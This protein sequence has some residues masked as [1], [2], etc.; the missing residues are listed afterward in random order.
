MSVQVSVITPTKNRLSLLCE[1]IDSVQAQT[2]G[3]WEHLIVD[4]GSDDGTSEEVARHAAADPRIRYIPRVSDHAGANV[5]R[6]IGIRESRGDLIV[7]L[8]SDDLLAPGCLRQRVEVLDR[9]RDLD[10]AVFPSWVFTAAADEKGQWFIP[11]MLGS[12][13]DLFLYLEH[14][15]PITGPIWRRAALE[16]IGSLSEDLLSWQD[17]DLN[18]RALTGRLKYLRFDTPDHH[19]RWTSDP[20]KT[21]V[22]QFVSP[23]HL[24]GATVIVQNFQARLLQRGLMTWVRRR[25]L[26]GLLFLL[27][28]RW[29]RIGQLSQGLHVWRDAYRKGLV[30]LFVYGAGF[31]V[32]M[33]FKLKILGPTYSERLLERF[34]F[35]VRFRSEP[36]L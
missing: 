9:N 13:L 19:I 27:A 30:P 17:V 25:A 10:F 23:S 6:N 31:L 11:P 2:F 28:E 12:D 20:T 4:D 16:K 1:T 29:I 36:P 3:D 21:S 24:K 32:L 18:V 5:C 7:F 35:A 34:R 33:G 22:H 14:P 26:G 8:D 15:W